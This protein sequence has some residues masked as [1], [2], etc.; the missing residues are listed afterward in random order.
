M[1]LPC[2]PPQSAHLRFSPNAWCVLEGNPSSAFGTFSPLRRGEGSRWAHRAREL[3]A[4]QFH[5]FT[6]K[7]PS[8]GSYGREPARVAR[9]LLGV[10][11][12]VGLLVGLVIGGTTVYFLEGYWSDR[13]VPGQPA[14]TS[15]PTPATPEVSKPTADV[16]ST[17]AASPASVPIKP[18]EM[19]TEAA[20]PEEPALK[21][22]PALNEPA[23]LAADAIII[24]VVG[25]RR[26]DLRPMFDE[27]RGSRQHRAIDI[28]APRATPVL[29]AID[30]T[31]GKLF[32]SKPGGITI[33]QYDPTRSWIYYYA[34]L[35]GYAPGLAEGQQLRRGDVIGFVGTSGNAPPNAPHLHFAIE[36]LSEPG[37]WWVSEPIDPYPLL[38]QRGVTVHRS[39]E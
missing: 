19:P 14:A 1:A 22:S 6:E 28:G 8:E 36:K 25:A 37:K 2:A 17:P 24:P 29:A 32:L 26:E 18:A 10:R 9:I 23:G 34:H 38:M 11:F 39:A 30:G 15:P 31:V 21:T 4:R 33:Y 20:I 3:L 5:A 7:T 16:V 27:R 35:D 13:P 12:T